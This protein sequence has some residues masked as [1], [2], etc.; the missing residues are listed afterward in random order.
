MSIFTYNGQWLVSGSSLAVAGDCCCGDEEPG[1][2]ACCWDDNGVWV[3]TQE[4]E[5]DCEDILGGTWQGAGKSCDD[6]D[7]NEGCCDSITTSDG[8]IVPFCRRGY[9][10]GSFCVPCD[11]DLPLPPLE[12]TTDCEGGTPNQVAVACTGFSPNTG[13]PA[14][15][16]AIDPLINASYQI[17]LNCSAFGEEDFPSGGYTVRVSA[18]LSN[19]R[20]AIILVISN[21]TNS[22]VASVAFNASS[23]TPSL[24]EC[25]HPVYPCSDYSGAASSGSGTGG[26]I[27][28]SGV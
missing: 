17:D 5:E 21:V 11:P 25:G 18:G 7:C 14:L 4:S 3:C 2:G 22:G 19:A 13:D 1:K 20:S 26:T 6:I 16:A 15:D 9:D 27:S 28:V 24:A 12:G 23:E 8:C 10:A